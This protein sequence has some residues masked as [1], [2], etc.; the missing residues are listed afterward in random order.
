[1]LYG[2]F[3]FELGFTGL[4]WFPALSLIIDMSHSKWNFILSFRGG[5]NQK[6]HCW[7]K[8]LTSMIIHKLHKWSF[9]RQW[10]KSLVILTSGS[11]EANGDLRALPMESWTKMINKRLVDAM[12][13]PM[14]DDF[15]PA[16]TWIHLDSF[17]NERDCGDKNG[18]PHV[19]IQQT[20]LALKGADISWF[21]PT[22]NYHD[23]IFYFFFY[24]YIAAECFG[25]PP[26]CPCRNHANLTVDPQRRIMDLSSSFCFEGS[27]WREYSH[28]Y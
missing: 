9:W 18:F 24:I 13:L 6:K 5:A 23:L 14:E 26:D 12:Q 10:S 2:S 15:L 16:S 21:L 28:H 22:R 3:P 19:S 11:L 7:N 25:H 27:E 1:M 4:T 17:K 20:Y 8:S